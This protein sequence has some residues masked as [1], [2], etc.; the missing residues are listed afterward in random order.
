MPWLSTWQKSHVILKQLR[1]R[2]KSSDVQE[3][4][5]KMKIP[6]FV[7]SWTMSSP[8]ASGVSL[9]GGFHSEQGSSAANDGIIRYAHKKI[10]STLPIVKI[11]RE[12]REIFSNN[13]SFGSVLNHTIHAQLDPSINKKPWSETEQATFK[14]AHEQFG[15][16][17]AEIA[18][19]LPGRTDNAV[20]N[21]WFV[22]GVGKFDTQTLNMPVHA[23]VATIAHVAAC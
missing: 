5:L 13:I 19:L 14:A 17:W 7:S 23:L 2:R 21:F 16:S 18:K 10:W 3:G 20:K 11:S 1:M 22:R 9:P 8:R 6:S 15:N 12:N 4:G